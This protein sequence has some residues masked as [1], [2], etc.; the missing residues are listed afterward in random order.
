MKIIGECDLTQK[1][2]LKIT[3][4]NGIIAHVGDVAVLNM[5]KSACGL[6]KNNPVDIS[7]PE[8]CSLQGR[9]SFSVVS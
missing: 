5:V 9:G 7:L 4:P 2:Y 3:L 6:L 1:G 8:N